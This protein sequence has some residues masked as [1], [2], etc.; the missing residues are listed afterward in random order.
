MITCSCVCKT[1]NAF[2]IAQIPYTV[3]IINICEYLSIETLTTTKATKN[4]YPKKSLNYEKL[5]ISQ[6]EDTI[7]L[8]ITSIKS[9]NL[10]NPEADFYLLHGANPKLI[11]SFSKFSG[12]ITS[13]ILDTY[14]ILYSILNF[15]TE[16]ND[17]FDT[18]EFSIRRTFNQIQ[19][20]FLSPKDPDTIHQPHLI[21]EEEPLRNLWV[22]LFG[23]KCYWVSFSQF[24]KDYLKGLKKVAIGITSKIETVLRFTV[25]FPANDCVSTYSVHLLGC[26]WGPFRDISTN[27]SEYALKDGFAGMINMYQA[28]KELEKINRNECYLIRYSRQCPELLTISHYKNNSV[29]HTRKARTESIRTLLKKDKIEHCPLP[30]LFKWAEAE[31]KSGNIYEYVTDG[32]Y[33][34]YGYK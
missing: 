27:I 21:I 30:V 11:S 32:D 20:M 23:D 16:L 7:Q 6:L 17:N 31:Q 4:H 14:K 22:K 29:R 1:W 26:H 33:Y 25:H 18:I 13:L 3:N 9:F 12:I 10:T 8:L 15:E 19:D 28:C 34:S 5:R 24:E 2:L